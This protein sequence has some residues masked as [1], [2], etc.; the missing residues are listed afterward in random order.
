MKSIC[1]KVENIQKNKI[2]FVGKIKKNKY[3]LQLE[4]KRGYTLATIEDMH[5]FINCSYIK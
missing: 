5:K 1:E 3:P 2:E 4:N